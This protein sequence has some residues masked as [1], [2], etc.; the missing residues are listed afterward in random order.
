M[1]S[2][3]GVWLTNALALIAGERLFTRVAANVTRKVCLA[4]G[5]VAALCAR[6]GERGHARCA[7]LFG[8]RRDGHVLGPNHRHVC[9]FDRTTPATTLALRTR[10][11]R[12]T[13]KRSL[14][15][16]R[17]ATSGLGQVDAKCLPRYQSQWPFAARYLTAADGR[18]NGEKEKA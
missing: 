14:F 3:A 11:Q 13:H 12:R 17:C 4:D 7:R 6:K 1:G 16:I 2:P 10:G 9:V 8:N 18:C 5:R 15:W